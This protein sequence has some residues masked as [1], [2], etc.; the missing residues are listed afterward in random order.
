MKSTIKKFGIGIILFC[1]M[2][3]ILFSYWR[4]MIFPKSYGVP[5]LCYHK[6]STDQEA[7]SISPE[8]FR[9]QLDAL[10]KMGY[11][12]ISLKEL[13]DLW[14]QG[15]D[16]LPRSLV[17][18][19]DDGY[20]NNYSMAQPI[21][22]EEGF[23]ATVFI[24]VDRKFRTDLLEWSEITELRQEGWEIGSHSWSHVDLTIRPDYH[25]EVEIKKSRLEIAKRSGGEV[26]WFAYPYGALNEK[27]EK[28]VEK[29]G[30]QGAVTTRTGMA[31]KTDGIYRLDRISITPNILPTAFSLKLRIFK[32]E[33]AEFF[34]WILP[35]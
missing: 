2:G 12:S 26:G 28:W 4:I 30:Y 6:I 18:T 33:V 8:R 31:D 19:F 20:E 9:E 15:K 22:K 34:R 25:G 16:P 32:A 24:I 23:S 11:H 3:S 21:L 27:T 13:G 1:L 10:R 7:M 35:S 5:I 14:A 17:I 29:S